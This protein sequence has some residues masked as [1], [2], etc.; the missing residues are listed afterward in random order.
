MTGPYRH[1]R[2]DFQTI[3]H[4]AECRRRAMEIAGLLL[5]RIR[6]TSFRVAD[7]CGRKLFEARGQEKENIMGLSFGI[8]CGRQSMT[9]TVVPIWKRLMM[10]GVL[11]LAATIPAIAQNAELQQKLAAVKQAMAENR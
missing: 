3:G 6:S 1:L 5:L 9:V 2:P 10:I 11:A 4:A 8:I 7:R